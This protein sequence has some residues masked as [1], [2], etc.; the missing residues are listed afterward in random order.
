MKANDP[1]INTQELNLT[2]ENTFIATP[3]SDF[4]L[5]IQPFLSG[6]DAEK[7]TVIISDEYFFPIPSKGGDSTYYQKLT[8]LLRSLKCLKIVYTNHPS[9]PTAFQQV[10]V[11]LAADRSVVDNIV[12]T[13]SIHD[14]YWICPESRKGFTTGTSP[15]GMA[16]KLSHINWIPAEDVDKLTAIY[17]A[18]NV[19]TE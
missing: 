10:K 7:K 18:E 11:A 12:T 13:T 14:R 15:N 8:D 6:L 19:Y 17:R 1:R 2:S 4:A 5:N 3:G 9:H 16:G